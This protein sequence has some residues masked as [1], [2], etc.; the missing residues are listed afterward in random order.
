[1]PQLK[2]GAIFKEARELKGFSLRDVG[3][4]SLINYKTI[5]GYENNNKEP[6]FSYAVIL[7]DLYEID[8]EAL[9]DLVLGSSGRLSKRKIHKK[10]DKK[11]RIKLQHFKMGDI[12]REAREDM[13]LTTRD[14]S[15]ETLIDNASMSRY[16]NNRQEPRLTAAI[17]LCNF[18][19]V[20]VATLA[21]IVRENFK[22]ELIARESGKIPLPRKKNWYLREK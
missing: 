21:N 10:N 16:E 9:V 5:H 12:F 19:E 4:E 14:V 3:K 8:I 7:C 22:A 11:K 20:G 6:C 17:I 13:G 2:I 1:M 18:Y 15:A